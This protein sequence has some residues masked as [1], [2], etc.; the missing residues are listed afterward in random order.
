MAAGLRE[1]KKEK[2]REALVHTALTLFNRRGF[3]RVTVE[4]IA[5]ACDVSPRTFFRYFGSKEDVL[6]AD[7][8][9]SRAL[10]LET[11]D[12]QPADLSP[13][14]SL[15]KA[16]RVVAQEKAHDRELLRARQEITRTTPSLRTGTAERQQRW[17][18]DVVDHLRASGRAKRMTD[19]DLRLL[20]ASTTTAL[21]VAVETWLAADDN[22]RLD[23]HLDDAFR[24]LRRGFD[25]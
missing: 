11:L 13:F 18:A 5:D 20:V 9:Q 19:L 21:R 4:E 15:E 6:F 16:L 1:R 12:T 22:A 17:E 8:D 14:D 24:R 25:A 2:T 23:T 10:L 3:D 7:S